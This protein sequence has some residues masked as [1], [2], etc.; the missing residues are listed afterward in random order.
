MVQLK[1]TNC[2]SKYP[3][4]PSNHKHPISKISKAEIADEKYFYMQIIEFSYFIH[5]NYANN[6]F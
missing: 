4:Y 2:N 1:S 5:F 6:Y 3:F